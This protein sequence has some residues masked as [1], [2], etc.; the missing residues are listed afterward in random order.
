M[1]VIPRRITVRRDPD[2]GCQ[3]CGHANGGTRRIVFHSTGYVYRVCA[4]HEREYC[5]PW[6]PRYHENGYPAIVLRPGM[7]GWS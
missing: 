6:S 2:M 7:V 4:E 3:D 5:G 1:T